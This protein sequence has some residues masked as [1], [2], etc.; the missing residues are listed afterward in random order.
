[1]FKVRV[2]GP[3][4]KLANQWCF[5]NDE[6]VI[7]A[8][9]LEKNKDYVEVIEELEN[10]SD[11]EGKSKSD[12]ENPEGEGTN[13]EETDEELEALKIRAKNLGIKVKK[14]MKKETLIKKIQ[15]KTAESGEGQNPDVE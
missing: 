11:T 6:A 4:V 15:E 13:P 1:M 10:N 7:D 12:N 2:K 3:G 5:K 8:E 14:N 9:E